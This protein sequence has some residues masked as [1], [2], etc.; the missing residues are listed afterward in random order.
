MKPA[1]ASSGLRVLLRLLHSHHELQ[2][3]TQPFSHRTKHSTNKQN[4]NEEKNRQKPKEK[5]NTQTKVSNQTRK[6]SIEPLSD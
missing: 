5:R 1:V 2:I 6:K 3:Q 4:V